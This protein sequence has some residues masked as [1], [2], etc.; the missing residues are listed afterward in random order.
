MVPSTMKFIGVIHEIILMVALEERS[1]VIILLFN[2]LV[3]I[4]QLSCTVT[5]LI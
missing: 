4:D 1:G 3:F 2:H 5:S